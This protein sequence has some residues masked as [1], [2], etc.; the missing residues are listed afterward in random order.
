MYTTLHI[1]GYR[2]FRTLTLEGLTR[3]TLFGGR[4]NAGKTSLLEAI[5]LLSNPYNAEL[6]LRVNAFRG[7]GRIPPLTLSPAHDWLESLGL[8]ALFHMWTLDQPIVLGGHHTR[9]G[10]RKFSFRAV[11]NPA[12]SL[13]SGAIVPSSQFVGEAQFL[14]EVRDDLSGQK[15]AEVGVKLR[16]NKEAEVLLSSLVS[17]PYETFFFAPKVQEDPNLLAERFSRLVENGGETA[18]L[19]ALRLIEPRLERVQILFKYGMPLIGGE[20][21]GE[22]GKFRPLMMMGDGLM[23]ALQLILA[24]FNAQGGVLLVDEIEAGFHFSVQPKLWQV[25][26]ALSHQFDVQIFA[27]THSQEMIYAAH[28]ALKGE[29]P[30]PL[31]YYRLDRGDA[32]GEV[33]TAHYDHETIEGAFAFDFEVRG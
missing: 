13:T 10:E 3:I 29:E 27:T 19:A 7:L 18:L 5:F 26:N 12:Q 23:R 24:F 33:T 1:E 14:V 32:V 28:S 16:Q 30:Y 31:S 17:P 21:K 9:L 11:K 6:L 22:K 25:L 8:D 2:G 4:N 15:V 20:L